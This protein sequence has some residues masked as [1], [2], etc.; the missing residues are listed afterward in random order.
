[1]DLNS[2][3]VHKVLKRKGLLYLYHANTVK[4]SKTFIKN[5]ALLSR[6]YIE[7]NGLE[8]TP[9]KSDNIDK[10]YEIWNYIFL[11][12][13]NISSYFRNYNY[14]GP[15]LFIFNIDLL[16]EDSIPT[17][18]ISK[19]NPIHWT[20]SD[21]IED[22]YYESVDEFDK[23]FYIGNK[24]RDGGNHIII[25]NLEGKLELKTN[26]HL[27]QIDN[28]GIMVKD[29]SDNKRKNHAEAI[30]DYFIED[31]KKLGFNKSV[32]EIINN[33]ILKFQYFYLHKTER[34]KYKRLFNRD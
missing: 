13:I 2:K 18:R 29:L 15:V 23:N 21:K 33:R 8:Q 22:R 27:I 24:R 17:V 19:K 20:D 12:A 5:G 11:D 28:P 10:K 31:I 3:L 26:L 34:G 30:R 6:K 9:Q 14:Y 7:Q 25:T 16:L 32:L 4:T 1:M